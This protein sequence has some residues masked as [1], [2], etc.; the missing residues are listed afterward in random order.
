VVR[1]RVGYA[2]GTRE[3]PTYRQLGDHSET[4]QIDY[5]P[6]VISYADLLQVFWSSHRPTQPPWSR[7]YMSVIFYHDE[8]QRQLAI[9]SK[10]REVERLGQ[11][12][13][14]EVVPFDRFYRAEDYHQK[15]RL[16]AV[17]EFMDEFR[18]IY[19]NT[20]DFVDS[21][22]VARVNGYAGGN[23]T[24]ENLM[25]EAELLGLSPSSQEALRK[26]VEAWQR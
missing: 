26:M 24:L 17:R 14:T 19:P 5:D 12:V 23:G 6:T 22:A 11:T 25:A 9:E 3:N 4:I 16:R 8:Q 7:Q 2:G 15:Y 18:A 21:T 20:R 13:Y 10:A 1:T